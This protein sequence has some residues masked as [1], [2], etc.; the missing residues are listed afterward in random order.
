MKHLLE[1]GN[2]SLLLPE[3]E[4]GGLSEEVH[5]VQY[6]TQKYVVRRCET[7]KKA[8]IYEEISRTSG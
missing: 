4:G 8:K 3:G 5:L 1:K 6:D 7:L 2:V